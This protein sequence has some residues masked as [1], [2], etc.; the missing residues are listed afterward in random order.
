LG[1]GQ[2]RLRV[3]SGAAGG[4]PKQQ[5]YRQDYKDRGDRVKLGEEL[6]GFGALAE[7]V[8]Q[9]HVRRL[10]CSLFCFKHN[11]VLAAYQCDAIQVGWR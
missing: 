5:Q 9:F 10:R 3:A 7:Y 2:R 8:R 11:H 4:E 6:T 1:G